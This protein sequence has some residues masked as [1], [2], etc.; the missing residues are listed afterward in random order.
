[1]VATRD[2]NGGVLLYDTRSGAQ[3]DAR[4]GGGPAVLAVAPGND[5]AVTYVIRSGAGSQVRSC[6]LVN[7]YCP[8]VDLIG[9]DGT[10]VLAR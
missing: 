7:R 10:A 5:G 9:L 4:L 3:L 8:T 2:D 1:M 6:E